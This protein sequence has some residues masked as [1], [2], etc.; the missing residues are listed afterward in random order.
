MP[1]AS[2]EGFISEPA[3]FV[4]VEVPAESSRLISLPFEPFDA[5]VASLFSNQADRVVQWDQDA[6][7]YLTSSKGE[8]DAWYGADGELSTQTLKLGEGFWIEN[9]RERQNVFLTGKVPLNG[10]PCLAFC[11]GLNV[12]GLPYPSSKN[13]NE[14]ELPAES[15]DRVRDSAGTA[16]R[17]NDANVL[18]TP[19]SG[20]WY[21]RAGTNGSW[22]SPARPYE[23]VFETGTNAPAIKGLSA[24]QDSVTLSISCSGCDGERL[25]ILYTDLEPAQEWTSQTGWCVAAEGLLT[26]GRTSFSWTDNGATNRRAVS[27]VVCRLYLVAR[28]DI[29]VDGDGISDA[30]ESFVGVASSSGGGEGGSGSSE[31]GGETNGPSQSPVEGT[32][33]VDWRTG[34]DVNDGLAPAVGDGHG[35]VQ[36]V[37]A[38]VSV[39]RNG[40]RIQVAGG[41]YAEP[42]PDL[43]RKSVTIAPAGRVVLRPR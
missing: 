33:Y 20:W 27:E 2:R 21:E 12:F 41:V 31:G 1:D 16:Y 9:R 3:G 7:Q 34:S 18:L 32:I 4:R 6:Q 35:P 15:L 22:W 24:G 19:G 39:A 25:E 30:R 42:L 10:R 28:Q 40:G 43:S 11:P 5:R 38:G 14:A 26:T 36:T 8:D 23:D 13:L 29:D 17:P 37:Q